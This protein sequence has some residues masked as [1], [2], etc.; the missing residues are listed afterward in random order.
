[1]T[2]PATSTLCRLDRSPRCSEPGGPPR[3]FKSKR[4]VSLPWTALVVDAPRVPVAAVVPVQDECLAIV[5]HELRNAMAPM[6]TAAAILNTPGISTSASEQAVAILTRQL[7]QMTR[8][9][10]DLLDG[11]SVTQGTLALK[12]APTDLQTILRD[13]VEAVAP[14][15]DQRAQRVVVSMPSPPACVLGD[16][17]RLGQVFVNLLSNASKFTR[18]G[19]QIWLNLDPADPGDP[20]ADLVVRV[21]DD[22][23]GMAADVSP[24]VFDLFKQG[25]SSPHQAP[26]L[27]VGLALVRGIVERHGGRVRVQSSGLGLG[28]EFV[29]SLPP[30]PRDPL[31]L[32][33]PSEHELQP[34]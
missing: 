14:Q 21:R 4:R 12:L 9:V 7:R 27:G 8:L 11:A 16:G 10:G 13:S 26:G 30:H 5:A 28:S 25:P 31:N 32:P 19:G 23:I 17:L 29:V 22:G 15:T 2:Y 34:C 1:M 3:R 24:H 20:G 18:Q 33:W 6:A